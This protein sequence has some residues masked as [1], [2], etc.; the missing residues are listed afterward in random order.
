VKAGTRVKL[1]VEGAVQMSLISEELLSRAYEEAVILGRQL[2]IDDFV[3]V[4][5][6]IQVR[7]G[8][9]QLQRFRDEEGR[10]ICYDYV[11]QVCYTG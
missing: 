5:M 3:P 6:E 4:S 2:G 11:N 7:P 8:D 1:D 9:T 10:F